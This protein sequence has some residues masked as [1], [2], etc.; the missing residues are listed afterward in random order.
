MLRFADN[1]A[2]PLAVIPA[3]R[4]HATRCAPSR[5]IRHTVSEE[6]AG[7]RLLCARAFAESR[8]NA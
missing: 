5:V 8:D 3:D 1:S 4:R 6:A 2:P 7:L